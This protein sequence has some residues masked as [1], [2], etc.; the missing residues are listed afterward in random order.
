MAEG[1]VY[2][3]AKGNILVTYRTGLFHADGREPIASTGWRE[4]AD[5]KREF[6]TFYSGHGWLSDDEIDK[7]RQEN[8]R[9]LYR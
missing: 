5:G 6:V 9:G 4:R 8:P 1:N 3:N 7:I 2:T